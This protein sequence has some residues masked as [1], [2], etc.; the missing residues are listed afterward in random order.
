MTSK[1]SNRYSA[2]IVT[3]VLLG[4]SSLSITSS[5][6]KSALAQL[7][8]IYPY[9][10]DEVLS[11]L[12]EARRYIKAADANSLR[13]QRLELNDELADKCRELM[14]AYDVSLNELCF[15]G[16][17]LQAKIS[18]A[19]GQAITGAKSLAKP[20]LPLPSC[21]LIDYMA[22]PVRLSG[23]QIHVNGYRSQPE[24]NEVPVLPESAMAMVQTAHVDRS[25]SPAATPLAVAPEQA[26]GSAEVQLTTSIAPS[27]QVIETH[28]P[29]LDVVN[30]QAQ[31]G[32]GSQTREHLV[33]APEP[34]DNLALGDTARDDSDSDEDFDALMA[35]LNI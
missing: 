28:E 14:S 6:I 31:S 26:V 10:I 34:T 24:T 11:A 23:T 7:V 35:C 17:W 16:V 33:R 21:S 15:A 19:Y 30:H 3:P 22:T 1:Q 2:R 20:S 32:E 25:A 29:P 13:K 5:V 18:L 8:T 12:S 27:V 9:A 4:I